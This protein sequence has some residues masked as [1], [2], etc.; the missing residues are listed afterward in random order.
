MKSLGKC[1]F[2]GADIVVTEK[3]YRCSNQG[4]EFGLHDIIW[5]NALKSRGGCELDERD[6]EA[7]LDGQT[8]TVQLKSKKTERFYDARAYY[9]F[10]TKKVEIEFRR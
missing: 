1:S 9:D 5:K 10:E 7:L 2:C 8:I 4:T 6:A 3:S